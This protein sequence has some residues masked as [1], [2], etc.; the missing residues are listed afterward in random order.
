[1][2]NSCVQKVCPFP[3]T[4][5]VWNKISEVLKRTDIDFFIVVAVQNFSNDYYKSAEIKYYD[6]EVSPDVLYDCFS[7]YLP[8]SVKRFLGGSNRC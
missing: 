1:M 7:Y 4:V 6:R 2:N 3:V 5:R 8:D